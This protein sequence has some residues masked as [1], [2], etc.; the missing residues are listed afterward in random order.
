M[1]A[2]RVDG[3]ERELDKHMVDI[4]SWYPGL[5][6]MMNIWSLNAQTRYSTELLLLTGFLGTSDWPLSYARCWP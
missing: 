5:L 3:F 1:V 6:V 2:T 4:D